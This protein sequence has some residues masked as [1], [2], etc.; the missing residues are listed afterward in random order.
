MKRVQHAAVAAAFSELFLMGGR[1]G[2]TPERQ[3]V[4]RYC[5]ERDEWRVVA[6]MLSARCALGA[7]AIGGTVYAVAGQA[8]RVTFGTVEAL[9]VETGR[10]VMLED[11]LMVSRRMQKSTRDFLFSLFLPARWLSFISRTACLIP[12]QTP[13]KYLSASALHGCIYAAG[14]MT[15]RRVRLS[16]VERLDPREVRTAESPTDGP[17]K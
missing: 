13:R 2:T 12:T 3:G 4:E 11:S 17:S 8:G 14:G 9:D 16:S 15:E 5:P 6:P 10:W 7:A 1:V